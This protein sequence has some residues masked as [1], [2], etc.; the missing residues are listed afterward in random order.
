M[1]NGQENPF[2]KVLTDSM[3]ILFKQRINFLVILQTSDVT[4]SIQVVH[5]MSLRNS[6]R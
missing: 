3:P 4:I 6:R 2:P 5:H 1:L